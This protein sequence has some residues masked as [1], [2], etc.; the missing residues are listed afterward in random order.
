MIFFNIFSS[1]C[2]WCLMKFFLRKSILVST[3]TFC[4]LVLAC[5]S[6]KFTFYEFAYVVFICT[7]LTSISG[8]GLSLA[9]DNELVKDFFL[10]HFISTLL[11]FLNSLWCFWQGCKNV[12]T[13]LTPDI[14]NFNFLTRFSNNLEINWPKHYLFSNF[15]TQTRFT[16]LNLP[17]NTSKLLI[18]KVLFAIII[19]AEIM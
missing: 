8:Q 5:Y 14:A 17:F 16:G 11:P 18:Y 15:C 4:S 10:I 2:T 6:T 13:F 3:A 1:F 19:V 12:L 7:D 9:S